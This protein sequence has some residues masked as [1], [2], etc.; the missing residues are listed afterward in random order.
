MVA[1]RDTH[2]FTPEF[3]LY[4]LGK[5]A[6][7]HDVTGKECVAFNANRLFVF[8]RTV[9]SLLTFY[10]VVSTESTVFFLLQASNFSNSI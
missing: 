7:S 3:A 9:R 4:K 10:V 2:N 6:E 1:L 5:A 8:Y